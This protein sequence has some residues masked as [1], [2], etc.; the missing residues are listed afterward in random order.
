M[1]PSNSAVVQRN[2]HLLLVFASEDDVDD[3]AGMRL[4][5]C[6]ASEEACQLLL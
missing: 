3:F 5:H 1:T 2:L 4:T 6:P